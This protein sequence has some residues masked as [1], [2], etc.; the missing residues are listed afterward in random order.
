MAWQHKTAILGCTLL[1]LCAAAAYYRFTPPSYQATTEVAVQSKR[2]DLVTGVNNPDTGREDYVAAQMARLSSPVLVAQAVERSKLN[3]LPSLSGQANPTEAILRTLTVTRGRSQF[4]ENNLLSLS[5]RARYPEDC[6][7]ILSALLETHRHGMAMAYENETAGALRAI[8]QARDGVE[9]QLRRSEAAYAA[10]RKTHPLADKGVNGVSPLRQRLDGIQAKRSAV[11]LRRADLESKLKTVLAA[12]KAG[13]PPEA[14]LATLAGSTGGLAQD[15]GGRDRLLVLQEQLAP[16]L[17]EEQKLLAAYGPNHPDVQSV[18]QRIRAVRAL[19]ARPVPAATDAGAAADPIADAVAEHLSALRQTLQEIDTEDGILAAQEQ[20]TAHELAENE[21]QGDGYRADVAR[22]QQLYDGVIKRVEDVRLARDAGGYD[23]QVISPASVPTKIAPSALL[24]LPAGFCLGLFAGL[25]L[26]YRLATTDDR[27]RGA[28]EVCDQLGVPVLGAVPWSKTVRLAGRNNNGALANSQLC[29]IDQPNSPQAEAF[30]LVRTA[31]FCGSAGERSRI[32]QVSSPVQ[33]DG[34]SMLAANLAV[35]IAQA[36]K[37]VILVDANLRAP[38]VD[39]FFGLPAGPG[40]V[41]ALAGSTEPSE[42]LQPSGVPG[43]SILAAGAV[44]ANTAE[45]LTSRA[46]ADLL[47]WLREQ[48]DFVIVD[49]PAL[50]GVADAAVVA[51]RADGVL[52]TLRLDRDTRSDAERAMQRLVTVGAHVLGVVLNG[53]TARDDVAPVELARNGKHP[54]GLPWS[55]PA[56][57]QNVART[58]GAT[59]TSNGTE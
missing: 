11:L 49:S 55:E 22:A 37:R 35:A 38:K 46:F 2:S 42:A 43:L 8:M 10:F 20:K 15:S 25:G 48:A 45:M 44:P 13:Q 5:V 51:A 31:L 32:I 18:R 33:Q 58:G 19:F 21:T 50:L 9:Q 3:L 17:E 56:V 4:G 24:I 1:G 28:D 57:V 47:G 34:K 27:L 41:G 30:R 29:T 59:L 52:L 7:T 53:G 6:P 26:A 23:V 39:R 40:L 12:Q 16:L 14:L 54:P 36:G